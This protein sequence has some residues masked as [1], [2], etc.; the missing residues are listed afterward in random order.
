[1]QL[2]EPEADVYV[3]NLQLSQPFAPVIAT[4]V[5]MEQLVQ[6][7]EPV[8]DWYWPTEQLTHTSVCI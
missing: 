4:N 6:L 1:M 3:F 5:P 7:V 2:L 8:F